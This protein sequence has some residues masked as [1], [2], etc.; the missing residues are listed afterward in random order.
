[1]SLVTKALMGWSLNKVEK[2]VCYRILLGMRWCLSEIGP[3]GYCATKMRNETHSSYVFSVHFSWCLEQQR[4]AK[5]L[6][7]KVHREKL[8]EGERVWMNYW[9]IV[10]CN[11]G[12]LDKK[13]NIWNKGV[14]WNHYVW[15]NELAESDLTLF[16]MYHSNRMT[17][18]MGMENW[19]RHHVSLIKGFN[20]LR[21]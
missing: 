18:K 12:R 21:S 13:R 11:S 20:F 19:K 16:I 5:W 6:L 15:H 14:G 3:L 8:A 9:K 2:S 7:W 17:L 1:M 10:W 4:T